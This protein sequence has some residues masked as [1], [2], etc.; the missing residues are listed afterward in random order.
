MRRK[1]LKIKTGISGG[2]SNEIMEGQC[3]PPA[4]RLFSRE[5][6]IESGKGRPV[7]TTGD[8]TLEVSPTTFDKSVKFSEHSDFLKVQRVT[9]V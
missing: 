3:I 4:P 9:F 8:V 5:S 2:S 7:T 6:A 1:K